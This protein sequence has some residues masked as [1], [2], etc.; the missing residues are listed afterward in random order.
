MDNPW[1][2][3]GLVFFTPPE[4]FRPV[5]LETEGP[6]LLV[7]MIVGRAQVAADPIVTPSAIADGQI[8][9]TARWY[10]GS[11]AEPWSLAAEID[12]NW[13]NKSATGAELRTE[14]KS[15]SFQWV[16]NDAAVPDPAAFA[17][18]AG[19]TVAA[20]ALGGDA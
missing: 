7:A 1:F 2:D 3:S 8:I 4:G 19:G 17:G 15:A 14:F 10:R 16:T 12:G 13:L 11:E 5:T 9:G 20:V 18:S 6:A